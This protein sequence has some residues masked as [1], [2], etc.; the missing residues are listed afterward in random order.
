MDE[1]E[2]ETHLLELD[3]I[4]MKKSK[5]GPDLMQCFQW[6]HGYNFNEWALLDLV[7]G[8]SIGAMV[9]PQALRY[10]FCLMHFSH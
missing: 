5:K 2:V 3:Q 7:A 1:R 10:A 8:L 6:I 4:E 9:I